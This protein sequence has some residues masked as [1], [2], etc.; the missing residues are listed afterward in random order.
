MT[1]SKQSEIPW[2]GPRPY[3]EFEASRFFGR[4]VEIKDIL[5]R[6]S[7]QLT[8]L[9]GESAA[10]KSSLLCAGIAP[11]LWA[12]W[13]KS[14]I[15][16]ERRQL[17][18]PLILRDWGATKLSVFESLL[19]E[20]VQKGVRRAVDYFSLQDGGEDGVNLLHTLDEELAERR[21]APLALVGRLAERIPSPIV[22]VFDQFEELLRNPEQSVIADAVDFIGAVFEQV[23]N[24]RLL[25]SLRG[26]YMKYI[27]SLEY[28]LGGV[29]G[30]LVDLRALSPP[31]AAEAAIQA[32]KSDPTL[33]FEFEDGVQTRVAQLSTST[34]EKFESESTA[35]GS[36]NLLT[37][38]CLLYELA[39]AALSAAGEKRVAVINGATMESLR[40][41]YQSDVEFARGSISRWI[42]R[43]LS[44]PS[45]S[46]QENWNN[47]PL[48]Q[49]GETLDGMVYRAARLIAP[50]LSSGGFKI[51]LHEHRLYDNAFED[52]LAKLRR[53]KSAEMRSGYA[54]PKGALG[55][56]WEAARDV[57][58]AAYM[59]MLERLHEANVLKRYS[60]NRCELVHD[61][62]AEPYANWAQARKYESLSEATTSLVAWLG[63]DIDAAGL[64]PNR[65]LRNMVWRGA[66]IW[67]PGDH[68]ELAEFNG[69]VFDDCDLRGAIFDRCVFRGASFIGGLLDGVVFRGCEFL[70]GEDG[71]PTTFENVTRCQGLVFE[72]NKQ[73]TPEVRLRIKSLEFRDCEVKLVRFEDVDL[74][75]QTVFRGSSPGSIVASTVFERVRSSNGARIIFEGNCRVAYCSWDNESERAVLGPNRQALPE[76]RNC[77]HVLLHSHSVA[78]LPEAPPTSARETDNR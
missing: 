6:L 4:T 42:G 71:K 50:F 27:Y 78:P 69:T 68:P 23:P 13:L 39:T 40:K 22:L 76:W 66:W 20:V 38:Q 16:E 11:Q 59:E 21:Y 9:T 26:E 7:G 3:S 17:P 1:P 58:Q 52:D 36:L 57:H 32:A 56:P 24:V 19:Q 35:H 8:I 49:V 48:R 77:G 15:P 43:A 70:P 46:L 60:G 41:D 31:V 54:H 37:F 75:G 62:L 34:P 30:K 29:R 14:S 65:R 61:K 63:K 64:A 28:L 47:S 55:S 18:F 25:L 10:G 73:E 53:R 72:A 33:R 74:S 12:N 44:R 5:D 67:H 2:P 51:S 45:T